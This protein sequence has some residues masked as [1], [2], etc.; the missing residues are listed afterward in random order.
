MPQTFFFKVDAASWA[1]CLNDA[2]K[3]QLIQ[4]GTTGI[5]VGLKFWVLRFVVH[6]TGN[7]DGFNGYLM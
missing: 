2:A 5:P 7:D 6:H 4:A 1:R 3:M